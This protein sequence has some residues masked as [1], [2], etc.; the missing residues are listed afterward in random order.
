MQ[1]VEPD[2]RIPLPSLAMSTA[3][4]TN[5]P[6]FVCLFFFC[7]DGDDFDLTFHVEYSVGVF[8]ILAY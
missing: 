5:P 4:E 6:F 7:N 8:A 2:K 3:S 1:T